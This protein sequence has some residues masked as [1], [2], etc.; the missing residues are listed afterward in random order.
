MTPAHA[1]LP[2][3]G[4]S[5]WLK[6][7][8]WALMNQRYPES[9][10]SAESEQGTAA[11][12]V[13]TELHA[14]RKW[15]VGSQTPNGLIVT[16]EMIEGAELLVETVNDRMGSF[17]VHVEEKI[18][19]VLGYDDH[20]ISTFGTPDYWGRS[21]H[22]KHIEIVDY[23]FGHRFVDEWFNA[24]GLCY[25]AGILESEFGQVSK[26]ET[27]ITVSFTVVQP[28]CYYKGSPVRTHTFKLIECQPYMRA[29]KDAAESACD[30][31]PVATTNEQCCYCPGRHSC[32]ALQKAAYGDAEHSSART[33]LELSPAATA[34]E[35]KMLTRALDRLQ[36]RVD[37][38]SEQT[39]INL[40]RG[41]H[42]PYYKLDPTKGRTQWNLPHEQI[43]AMGE[44]FGVDLSKP[45]LITPTQAKKHIDE[46]VI[47]AYSQ[48]VST[49][50]KL[51][52]DDADD[53]RRIFSAQEAL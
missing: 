5:A 44:M 24:Q 11:H 42:V 26:L 10:S 7:A 18:Q 9:A 23:K 4:A 50:V 17:R 53:A 31:Q 27:D 29:L 14:G 32:D 34:L 8:M 3:S 30:P 35:L 13:G 49:G 47:M 22:T 16:E 39:L 45:A 15:P 52:E 19:I 51:V 6:C 33:P 40:K 46:S 28:R 25:L 20:S 2:P 1:F 12:W 38:L 48:S 43:L 41:E 21:G 37:G 36:A